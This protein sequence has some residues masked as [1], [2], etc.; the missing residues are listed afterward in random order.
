MRAKNL[1]DGPEPA[2][3]ARATAP[4]AYSVLALLPPPGGFP[5]TPASSGQCTDT[6]RA[7]SIRSLHLSLA[8]FRSTHFGVGEA[9]N[10]PEAGE[11]P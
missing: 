7:M 10:G 5:A 8:R 6:S 1:H 3:P 4:A 11:G 9:V 2:G